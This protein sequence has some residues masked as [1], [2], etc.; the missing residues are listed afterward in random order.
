MKITLEWI[1]TL[2]KA[3]ALLKNADWEKRHYLNRLERY[4]LYVLSS[5]EDAILQKKE[6][7]EA[8]A[9]YV[10][11]ETLVKFLPE[12]DRRYE[13]TTKM[14]ALEI[15]IRKLTSPNEKV[16]DKSLSNKE[17]Q[18]VK[19]QGL[20]SNIE[21]YIDIVSARREELACEEL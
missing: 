10:Y 20:I 18:V 21:M 13:E 1:D 11:H 14:M 15:K 16:I 3:D 8:Q 12:G 17:Y 5:E 9:K 19:L 7:A 4:N 2:E 6:L